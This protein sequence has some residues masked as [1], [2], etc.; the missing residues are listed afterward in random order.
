MAKVILYSAASLDQYIARPDGSIDWLEDKKWSLPG[1]D[2]GYQSFIE[3]I[4]FTLMGRKTFDQVVGFD[5][6]FPYTGKTNFVYTRTPFESHPDV[7]FVTSDPVAHARQLKEAADKDIWLIGGG[8]INALFLQAGLIDRCMI[9]YLP[10]LLGEGLPLFAPPTGEVA[11]D[12]VT[13][14]FYK[15]GFHQLVFEPQAQNG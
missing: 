2:F 13:S 12:I 4:G 9:T 10:M 8:Q 11:V 14:K 6:P 5:V 15:N 3:D 7:T 1:E